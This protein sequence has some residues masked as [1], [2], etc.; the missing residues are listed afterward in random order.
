MKSK[1]QGVGEGEKGALNTP[2]VTV[3]DVLERHFVFCI[4]CF[5]CLAT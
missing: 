5:V 3:A 4:C 2:A 1:E